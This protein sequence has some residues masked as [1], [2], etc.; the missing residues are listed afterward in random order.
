MHGLRGVTLFELS[1]IEDMRVTYNATC[2]ELG[3]STK[4]DKAT[5]LVLSKVVELAK[6]GL[7]SEE[8]TAQTLRFFERPVPTD[9]ML[10]P[11][12]IG[13]PDG[14][15]AGRVDGPPRL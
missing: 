10:P 1:L 15:A 4:S 11:A 12:V 3:L 13:R 5:M 8:L 14:A 6:A 9:P 2:K 7:R